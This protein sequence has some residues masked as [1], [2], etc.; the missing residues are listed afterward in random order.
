MSSKPG[1]WLYLLKELPEDISSQ[2]MNLIKVGFHDKISR[3]LLYKILYRG[4]GRRN[5]G[6]CC[7]YVSHLSLSMDAVLFFYVSV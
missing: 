6:L 2:F 3:I 4:M 1:L 7:T 5:F